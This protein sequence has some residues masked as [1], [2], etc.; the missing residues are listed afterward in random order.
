M[1]PA[2]EITIPVTAEV[3][4]I[5]AFMRQCAEDG[6]DLASPLGESALRLWLETPTAA[7]CRCKSRLRTW[8]R[9]NGKCDPCRIYEQRRLDEA[10]ANRTPFAR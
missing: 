10:L 6:I 3:V 4:S 5:K 2:A 9:L 1:I 7:V 8:E